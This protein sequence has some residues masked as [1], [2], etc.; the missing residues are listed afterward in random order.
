VKQDGYTLSLEHCHRTINVAPSMV[1]DA[2]ANKYLLE[3]QQQ[4][5]YGVQLSNPLINEN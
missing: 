2:K 3:L 4:H 1:E 5:N